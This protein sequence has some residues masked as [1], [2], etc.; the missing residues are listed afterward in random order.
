MTAA[1]ATT[2]S[3]FKGSNILN[4][5][6]ALSAAVKNGNWLDG[7]IA[8]LQGLGDA[9]AAL[10]D[11]IGT[12]VNCGLGWVINHLG[13]LKQ[14]LDKLAGSQSAVQAFAKT[15]T[16]AGDVMRQAGGTLATRL[17]DLEGMAGK[18]VDSYLAY[19]SDA[20]EHVAASGDWADSISSG[21]NTGSELVA[22]MQSVV[23]Q[24]I[25]SVLAT[26]IEAMAVVAASFGLGIGYAIARVVTKVNQIVNKVVKPMLQVLQSV[27]SLVGVVQSFKQ[28][29]GG[30]EKL[31]QNMVTVS[32]EALK[33]ADTSYTDASAATKL[34]A[35]G[36]ENLATA[37]AK[38]DRENADLVSADGPISGGQVHLANTFGSGGG[39]GV[40][41]A[42][43]GVGGGLGAA[44]S[45]AGLLGGGAAAGAAALAS[46]GLAG[47]MAGGGL[48]GRT[49]VAGGPTAGGAGAGARGGMG[50]M[51]G[52]RGGD[53]GS[54]LG[55]R[56]GRRLDIE[57]IPDD[58]DEQA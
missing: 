29:F 56:G 51:G 36:A 54:R 44:G 46:R 50:M 21:L 26:A 34:G 35:T 1:A 2:T 12:I 49:A 20:A 55:R 5:G 4:D 25:S 18:T 6:K 38:A 40:S 14:W 47:T 27:K 13:P 10:S 58:D 19:A 8:F 43:G 22:K 42:S 37:G 23:K 53:T 31:M 52:G 15:W 32:P 41:L 33:L 57:I 28:L 11:P 3:P 9:A 7:G 16:Q 45:G 48:L 17:K 30:S 24:G 39:V